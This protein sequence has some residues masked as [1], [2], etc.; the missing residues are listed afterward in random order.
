MTELADLKVAVDTAEAAKDD[1]VTERRANRETMSPRDFKA[2]N[3]ST[4][5]EQ[6]DVE[7]AVTAANKA[8][9]SAA[10]TIRSEAINVAIGTLSETNTPGGTS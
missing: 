2:Y 5:A 1:L 9:Q 10:T 8:F 7:K 4:W 3:E 6:I